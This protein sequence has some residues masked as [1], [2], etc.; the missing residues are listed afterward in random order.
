MADDDQ[1]RWWIGCNGE[2]FDSDLPP[3]STREDAIAEGRSQ[4]DGDAFY[5]IEATKCEPSLPDAEEINNLFIERNEDL[6][7]EDFY[8]GEDFSASPEQQAE[9]TE[10][11]HKLYSEWLTKHNLWPHVYNFGRTRNAEAIPETPSEG[12]TENGTA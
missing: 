3:G 6:G 7:G 8:F 11:F 12:E 4:Y 9:L 5:I 2:H 1:F 10:A